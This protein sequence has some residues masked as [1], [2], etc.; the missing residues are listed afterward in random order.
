MNYDEDIKG[1]FLKP[2]DLKI[3]L[4]V[5]KDSP[6]HIYQEKYNITYADAKKIYKKCIRIINT[7]PKYLLQDEYA[8]IIDQLQANL[9]KKRHLKK[10]IV[11]YDY[12]YNHLSL[13]EICKKYKIAQS[14]VYSYLHEY[15]EEVKSHR[16][17]V[18]EYVTKKYTEASLSELKNILGKEYN[19]DVSRATLCRYKKSLTK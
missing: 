2:E 4:L 9:Y 18:I 19:V 12:I 17:M 7:S 3:A 5:A 6:E 16:D 10:Q 1:K 13:N 15:N 8:A 14:T 11:V